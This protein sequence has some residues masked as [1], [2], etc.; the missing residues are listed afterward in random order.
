[1]SILAVLRGLAVTEENY[2]QSIGVRLN[3]LYFLRALVF[4]VIL[5]LALEGRGGGKE[6]I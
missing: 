5:I 4:V 6:E 1:M 2:T 3:Y